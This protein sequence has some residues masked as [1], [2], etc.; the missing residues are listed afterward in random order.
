M[1]EAHVWLDPEPAMYCPATH[2]VQLVPLLAEPAS[3]C[4][5]LLEL[6]HTSH[7]AGHCSH[8]WLGAVSVSTVPV[9]QKVHAVP[10]LA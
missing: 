10:L 9:P 7:P 2:L 6:R 4:W 3:H 8:R 1:H 5:Q